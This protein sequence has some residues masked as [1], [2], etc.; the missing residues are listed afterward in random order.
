MPVDLISDL[1]VAGEPRRAHSVAFTSVVDPATEEE[2][3]TVVSADAEDVDAAVRAAHA[4]RV[5]WASTP[6]AERCRLVRALAQQIEDRAGALSRTITRENGTPIAEATHAPAAAAAHLRYTADVA[7]GVLADEVRPNP[8]GTGDTIVQRRP[9]G[10][11]GLI[12]PWN[13]PLSLIVIKLAPALVAGCPVV[14]K[15]AAETPL[16]ARMLMDAVAA[17]GIPAGV[18]NLVTGGAATGQAL[19]DHPLVAKISFTGSTAVGRRIGETCGRLLRPVVLELGGKSPAL[20]LDDAEPDVIARSILKVSMRNTGQ[21]CKACT[22]LIVPNTR[23]REIVDLVADVVSSAPLGDPT[24]PSTFFGPL[25]SARQ[26]ERVLGY[27]ESGHAEGAKAVVCGGRPARPVRGFYV[28]PTVFDDVTPTMRIAREEIFGPVLSVLGYDTLD[29]GVALANDTP[30]GL[31]GTVFSADP[32]RAAAVASRIEAGTIGINHYGSSA[33]APFAG[34]KD[35]GLGV[36]L[37]PEGIEEFLAPT[38]IHRL[39]PTPPTRQTGEAR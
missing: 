19:V 5:A 24:D 27:L 15:P 31:A 32:E 25:V 13:Y 11:A 36:E 39:P 38:S 28:E 21:T 23:R 9:R 3:A 30:Y 12:T 18:V 6:V 1:F 37:G 34:H 4:V 10:V 29:E 35:S 8:H 33:A 2:I 26:R 14:V 17:A 22:R 7:P 16:A 20:V